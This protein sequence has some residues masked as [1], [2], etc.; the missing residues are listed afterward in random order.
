MKTYPIWYCRIEEAMF[1]KSQ[2]YEFYYL[3]IGHRPKGEPEVVEGYIGFT[4][5][6]AAKNRAK[7]TNCSDLITN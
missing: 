3:I 2:G 7:T 1:A 6:Q 5:L 4:T